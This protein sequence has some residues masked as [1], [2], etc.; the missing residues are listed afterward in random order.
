M[1]TKHL[2][3]VQKTKTHFRRKHLK[4]QRTFIWTEVW[5]QANLLKYLIVRSCWFYK[6]IY[7][8]SLSVK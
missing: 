6:S 5:L 7:T 4:M 8:C 2:R 3:H 1:L